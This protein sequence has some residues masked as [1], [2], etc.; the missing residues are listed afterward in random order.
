LQ[1]VK[2]SPTAFR[3]FRGVEI[4]KFIS[5]LRIGQEAAHIDE[6]A[7]DASNFILLTQYYGMTQFFAIRY[8][9]HA[10]SGVPL[11]GR[12]MQLSTG[13]SL[14]VMARKRWT[15]DFSDYSNFKH[16]REN[17]PSLN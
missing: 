1:I 11:K 7:Q 6:R 12:V 8:K 14:Y 17:V 16:F 10:A 13:S 9:P 4:I 2:G 5:F 15:K 3:I